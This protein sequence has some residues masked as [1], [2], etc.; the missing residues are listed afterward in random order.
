M[1]DQKS[2][3]QFITDLGYFGECKTTNLGV[4]SS[5][6]PERAIPSSEPPGNLRVSPADAIGGSANVSTMANRRVPY[7][8]NKCGVFYLQIRVPTGL[9]ISIRKTVYP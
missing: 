1:T 4:G 3:L 5:N 9:P 6:L 7:P 2:Q 8:Y